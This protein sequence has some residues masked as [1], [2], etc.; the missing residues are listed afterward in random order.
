M[1]DVVRM[2]A[3]GSLR[4]LDRLTD[5]QL[6]A[7][8]LFIVHGLAPGGVARRIG[9][10]PETVRAWMRSP[11]F[12][13]ACNELCRGYAASQLVPLA[14]VRVRQLLLDPGLK[15]RDAVAAGRFAAELAGLGGSAAEGG[16]FAP[17]TST[18]PV[19]DM[20]AEELRRAMLQGQAAQS[21]LLEAVAVDV[22]KFVDP[23]D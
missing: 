1:G 2:T 5:A 9:V 19:A 13:A 7:A 12:T 11:V 15:L 8:E 10:A 22:E 23:L 20:S 4:A 17:S 6:A 18:K 3:A 16:R 14:L 21:R